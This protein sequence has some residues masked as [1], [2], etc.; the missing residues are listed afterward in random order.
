MI[1]A[2]MKNY[3]GSVGRVMVVRLPWRS[4][5]ALRGSRNGKKEKIL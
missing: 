5:L 2:I 4:L 3:K 1:Q